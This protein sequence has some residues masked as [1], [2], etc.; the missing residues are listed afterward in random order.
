MTTLKTRPP[1]N[2]GHCPT[3]S[4][5]L[6]GLAIICLLLGLANGAIAIDLVQP[7]GTGSD[8]QNCFQ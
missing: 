4:I 3:Q 7:F 1:V 6:L 2:G 8:L 5:G